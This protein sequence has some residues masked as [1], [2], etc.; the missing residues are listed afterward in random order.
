MF[1]LLIYM[2]LY[3]HSPSSSLLTIQ[4]H[5]SSNWPFCLLHHISPCLLDH[6]YQDTSMLCYLPFIRRAPRAGFWLV[7]LP[8]PWKWWQLEQPWKPYGADGRSLLASW[9]SYPS[10]QSQP[11][12]HDRDKP[13][14]YLHQNFR[15]L[16]VFINPKN[17]MSVWPWTHFSWVL[18]W[19]FLW[20]HFI[21]LKH[22]YTCPFPYKFRLF[23]GTKGLFYLHPAL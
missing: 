14:S 5:C 13:L 8:T 23:L 6:S 15:D 4:G 7:T 16:L 10:S 1:P 11:D 12:F 19:Y 3:P 22:G 2:H 18:A 20:C 9:N 21:S 17:E